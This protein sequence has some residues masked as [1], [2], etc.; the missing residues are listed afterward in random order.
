MGDGRSCSYPT[1]HLGVVSEKLL[2]MQ[3]SRVLTTELKLA[4]PEVEIPCLLY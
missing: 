1:T 2:I 4:K 3:C